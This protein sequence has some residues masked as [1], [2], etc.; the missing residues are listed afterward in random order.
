ME[1]SLLGVEEL[2]FEGRSE[3]SGVRVVA[4]GTVSVIVRG[5]RRGVEVAV[6]VRRVDA[7]RPSLLPEAEKLHLAN[8]VGVGPSLLAASKNFLVWRYVEGWP[9]GE[10]GLKASLE[11]LRVVAR[12]LLRQALALDSIGLI[13]MELSRLGDHVLVTP[14]LDVVVFDFET[15]STSSGKSNVTQVVQGLLIRSSDLSARVR[16]ALGVSKEG[17]MRI[18]REYKAARRAEVLAPLLGD[19]ASSSFD[20]GRGQRITAS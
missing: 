3:I 8:S 14:R 13:H 9:L 6:K 10:W 16:E 4:K 17:A 12:E 15:A 2:V 11:E 19:R 5:K 20:G 1:L 18:A 7:N